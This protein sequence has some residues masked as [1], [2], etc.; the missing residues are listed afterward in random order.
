MRSHLA[1]L[2]VLLS[3]YAFAQDGKFLLPLERSAPA[4]VLKGAAADDAREA[5]I[6]L[7][8]TAMHFQQALGSTTGFVPK[9][10]FDSATANAR[11]ID[12]IIQRGNVTDADVAD[13]RT[14]R[15]DLQLK[16]AG[17]SR[18]VSSVNP[19]PKMGV[20]AHTKSNATEKS[21]YEVWWAY[22][23]DRNDPNAYSKF[24]RDSSPAQ[25]TLYPGVYMMYAEINQQKGQPIR[26][27]VDTATI[28]YD[29]DLPTP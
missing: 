17:Y 21:G 6:E 19:F 8:Q 22:F 14:I 16:A 13:I 20:L 18:F 15:Q 7:Q 9:E 12:Q 26:V 2:L 3:S 1:L 5:L 25:D 28:P 24:R 29:F 11:E 10:Y 27:A 23:S 4:G